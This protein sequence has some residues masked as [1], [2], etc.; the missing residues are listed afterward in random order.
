MH[1]EDAVLAMRGPYKYNKTEAEGRAKRVAH[2]WYTSVM[3][4]F[5][6]AQRRPVPF[7]GAFRTVP[8]R[9]VVGFLRA[10]F[11]GNLEGIALFIGPSTHDEGSLQ[12]SRFC[13]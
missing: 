3:C 5:F 8:L 2:L 12:A 9:G 6:V 11:W 4:V 1:R 7:L 13:Q 10:T